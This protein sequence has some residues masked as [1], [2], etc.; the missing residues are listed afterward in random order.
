MYP[1]CLKQLLE[2]LGIYDL[3]SGAGAAELEI[4]GGELNKIFDF[5]ETLICE[6]LPATASGYGLEAYETLL[7]YRPAYL[8][9]ADRRRA[10]EA[11]LRIRDGC[12]S[13]ALLQETIS[14]CGL[15]AEIAEADQASTLII[16]FPQNRGIPDNIEQLKSRITQIVPCHLA[17]EY[18]YIYS[19]WQEI[20]ALA[21]TWAEAQT[22]CEC[23]K[24]LEIVEAGG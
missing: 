22:L 16:R 18:Y 17:V 15:T 11:L 7:P 21:E 6:I 24:K 20:M 19:S 4:I 13:R 10:V 9:T 5:F 12:F 2:P 1:D 23:W 8:T 14:G 3:E